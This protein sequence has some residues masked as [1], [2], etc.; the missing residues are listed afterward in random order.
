LILGVSEKVKGIKMKLWS[1]FKGISY[2]IKRNY[3]HQYM[4]IRVCDIL[5]T[6]QGN[7]SKLSEHVEEDIELTKRHFVHPGCQKRVP[8]ISKE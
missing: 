1:R 7:K 6:A 3:V 2:E 8:E 4:K 5:R